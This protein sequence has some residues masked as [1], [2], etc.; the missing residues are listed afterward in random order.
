[1]ILTGTVTTEDNQ[2]DYLSAEGDTNEEAP[3][4]LN[5]Q[6]ADGQTLLVIRTDSY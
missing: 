2:Y 4:R 6:L 1:M 3:T 5:A